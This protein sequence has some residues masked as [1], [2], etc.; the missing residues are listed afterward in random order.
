MGELLKRHPEIWK[1]STSFS[2]HTRT[3]HHQQRLNISYSK[4]KIFLGLILSY[5]HTPLQSCPM[6]REPGEHPTGEGKRTH[7]SKFTQKV[8]TLLGFSPGKPSPYQGPPQSSDPQ[9]PYD[10]PVLGL[11]ELP[12]NPSG[13]IY[14]STHGLN[15]TEMSGTPPVITTRHPQYSPQDPS[16]QARTMSPEVPPI[17][18]IIIA[19]MGVT[20]KIRTLFK[21]CVHLLR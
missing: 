9:M 21:T 19:V 14:P 16:Q 6:D 7:F 12:G 4:N 15:P 13:H 3:G 1:L 5:R 18:E 17:P 11:A 20:G 10:R 2:H 8:E